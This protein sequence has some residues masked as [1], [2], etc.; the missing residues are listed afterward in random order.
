MSI[1]KW[2]QEIPDCQLSRWKILESLPISKVTKSGYDVIVLVES[3]IDPGGDLSVSLMPQKFRLKK[4]T[5]R[6]LGNWP[7]TLLIPSGEAIYH[8][9]FRVCD[10]LAEHTKLRKMICSSLTPWEMRT[11]IAFKH[12]PPVAEYQLTPFPTWVRKLTKH[13]I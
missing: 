9:A 1:S 3:L 6:N 7:K 10:S 4:L 11:S 12:D 5:S 8:S 13:R 2:L